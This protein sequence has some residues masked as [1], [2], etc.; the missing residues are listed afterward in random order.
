MQIT[1]KSQYATFAYSKIKLVIVMN[2]LKDLR[3]DND[4][5]QVKLAKLLSC[6]QTTYSR[7]ESEDL[8]IPVVSLKKLAKFYD[9][10]IDYLVCLTNEKKPY[11]RANK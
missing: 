4:L 2:R 10:S 3:E 6:S 9:T 8:N 5:T 1:H 7:Y 11:K